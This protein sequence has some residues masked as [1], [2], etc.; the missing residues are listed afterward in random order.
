MRLTIQGGSVSGLRYIVPRPTV[1][2][3][4]RR[5][6]KLNEA[7]NFVNLHTAYFSKAKKTISLLGLNNEIV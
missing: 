7:K 2:I 5:P 6:L 3:R 4:C 1:K